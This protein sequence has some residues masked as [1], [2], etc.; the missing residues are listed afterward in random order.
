MKGLIH[1]VFGM[2]YF[3]TM[4]IG[5]GLKISARY[6]EIQA[7]GSTILQRQATIRLLR[8]EGKMD[9]QDCYM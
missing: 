7:K 2:S 6:V 5:G 4:N 3:F 9:V 8:G 1:T